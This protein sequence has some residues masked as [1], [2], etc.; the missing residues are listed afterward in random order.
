MMEAKAVLKQEAD[1]KHP[2]S[3]YLVVE[4]PNTVTTWHLLVK[5]TAGNPDHRLMGAAWAALHGGYR[6]NRYQGP[7]KQQ[8][9]AKLRRMYAAEDMTPPGEKSMSDDVLVAYGGEIKDLGGGKIGGFLVRFTDAE[10]PDLENDY[11]TKDTDFDVTDGDGVTVYYAHGQ[12]PT[13]GGRKL[14]KGVITLKD[15]GV[16]IEAQLKLRDEYE[17]AIYR[18]AKEGKLGW[19]SGTLSHLV[20]R[21][22]M[23]QAQFIKSWPLG[24]DASLTP[25]PAAGPELTQVITFKS[26]LD[27]NDAFKALIQE[28][29]G[30]DPAD[31]AKAVE[32]TPNGERQ[33]TTKQQ[34]TKMSENGKPAAEQPKPVDVEALVQDAVNAA[35]ESAIKAYQDE[36][37]AADKKAVNDPGIAAPNVAKHGDVWKYDNYTAADLAT[38]L[39]FVGSANNRGQREI[40]KSHDQRPRMMKALALRLESSEA[41]DEA[42]ETFLAGKNIKKAGPLKVARGYMKA[43]GIKADETDFSTNANYGDEWIGVGYSGDLWL[44]VRDETRIAQRV[45]TFEFP[46]GVESMV[47]P[48]ESSDPVWYLVAQ[49]GDP[50]SSTAQISNVVPAK[51]LGTAQQTMSLG[52]LGSSTSYTG[53]MV[54]DS[55][56]PFVPALRRQIAVSGAEYLDASIIDGDTATTTT[57]NINDIAGTPAA[58][59]WF[60]IWDGFRKLALVTNTANS[61]DGGSLTSADFLETLKLLG[62]AGKVG[63]D[64]RR[65]SFIIDPWVHW[66][67]LELADV[68]TKDVFTGATLESGMLTRIFGYEVIHTY[69]MHYAGKGNTA[70][71]FKANTAG[72]VD[73]DTPSNNTT[74]SLLA[75]RWDYWRMGWQRRVTTEVERIPRA[76]AWEITSLLR[77]GLKYRDTDASAITYDLTV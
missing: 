24:K 31:D 29:S 26:W 19:S 66:K 25:T 28:G 12:D 72:K 77:A 3:H 22:P 42:E 18:M 21:V 34:E 62:P 32:D 9:I 27:S 70:Y 16:W 58:T 45:P 23:G 35:V 49:A 13:L 1:G 2:A 48:L 14:A 39:E 40:A 20:K 75:V 44:N 41:D 55:M 6:G 74:G 73:V 38:T 8:A 60:L 64:A 46:M 36:R 54:E 67:A 47:I 51:A 57:T 7:N 56:L 69:Q 10:H 5:D 33:E 4:D 71:E 65:T 53:E 52:K 15:I 50:T 68:K 17:E 43:A 30:N 76:D 63:M 11:F 37:A 61:R 59:D